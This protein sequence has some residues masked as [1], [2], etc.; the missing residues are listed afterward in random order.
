MADISKINLGKTE[1]NIKDN[2]AIKSLSIQGTTIGY[3]T[4][5]GSTGSISLQWFDVDN[6]KYIN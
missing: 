1:Y 6:N 3:S 5:R 2:S 4:R